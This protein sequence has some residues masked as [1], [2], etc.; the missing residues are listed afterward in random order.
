LQ[1]GTEPRGVLVPCARYKPPRGTMS[2]KSELNELRAELAE[3]RALVA[4]RPR[5]EPKR[6]GAQRDVEALI[7]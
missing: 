2:R 4:A 3:L 1:M 6:N 7:A 5:G